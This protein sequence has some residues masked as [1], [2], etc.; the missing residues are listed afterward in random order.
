MSNPSVLIH[1]FPN[2]EE[3]LSYRNFD[4]EDNFSDDEPKTILLDF[5]EC[6]DSVVSKD[7]RSMR[8]ARGAF[9]PDQRDRAV[10]NDR[11]TAAPHSMR[12]DGGAVAA[13]DSRSGD[14]IGVQTT[15]LKTRLKSF[16]LV[17]YGTPNKPR[18]A[19][20]KFEWLASRFLKYSLKGE[21]I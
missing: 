19:A 5:A 17:T 14:I 21:G 10:C 2:A 8:K 16:C 11:G 13:E 4:M 6:N 7:T 15:H 3:A 1:S 9:G 18:A 12:S 20:E